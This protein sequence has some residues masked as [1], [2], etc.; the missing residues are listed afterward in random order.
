MEF[1]CSLS[2]VIVERGCRVLKQEGEVQSVRVENS[3]MV[4]EENRRVKGK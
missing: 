3:F 1:E 2:V 4:I